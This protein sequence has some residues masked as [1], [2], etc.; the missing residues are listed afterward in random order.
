M[1]PGILRDRCRAIKSDVGPYAVGVLVP[2]A[3]VNARAGEPVSEKVRPTVSAGRMAVSERAWPGVADAAL[4]DPG[5]GGRRTDDR[6][7]GRKVLCRG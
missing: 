6:G 7:D 1:V 4:E 2:I 5:V 3:S